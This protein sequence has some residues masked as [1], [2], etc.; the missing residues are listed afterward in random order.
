MTTLP[1]DAE[2]FCQFPFSKCINDAIDIVQRH[3]IVLS[4]IVDKTVCT[5]TDDPV[6]LTGTAIGDDLQSS[7]FGNRNGHR[8]ETACASRYENGVSHF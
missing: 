2:L 1:Q 5:Q 3:R 7:V 6:T 8:T 4:L